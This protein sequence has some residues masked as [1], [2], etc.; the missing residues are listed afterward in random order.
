MRA[1][2]LLR[3][4]AL[5]ALVAL[6]AAAC[7]GSEE[8]GGSEGEE[9]DPVSDAA[10]TEG[11][12][13]AEGSEGADASE[14]G[15]ASEGTEGTEG[16][17][18][19]DAEGS[20]AAA[21]DGS[22]LV[23]GTLN[24]PASIDP[25]KCYDST[26]SNIL[27]NTTEQLVWFPPGEDTPEPRL[28]E[29]VE[30]SEDGLTYTFTLREGVTFHD[31]SELDADDVIYSLQ[32]SIDL[33]HPSGAAFLISAI[34]SMEAPDP[35]TVVITIAEAN[36][37]FLARLNY[38]IASIVPAESE[39][40]PTPPEPI[41]G[42]DPDA[43]TAEAD[44]FVNESSIIGTGPYQMTDYEEG[45]SMTLEAFPDYWD[46]APGYQTIRIQFF[47][48]SAQLANALANGEVDLVLNDLAPA[49]RTSVEGTDGIAVTEYSGG[50]I[51]YI[52]FNVNQPP[53]DNPD[54][55]RAVA[56]SID[57]QRIVDEVFEGAG[58]PL[59]SMI[60]SAFDVQ[61]DYVSDIEVPELGGTPIEF[62][63][64]YPLGRYGDTEPDVAET[65][66]RSLNESGLFNVTTE[67]AD[68]A[69][70]YSANLSTGA[71]GAF[72]LGWYPDY[73]D[74]D[75]YI[76][77]FYDSE[78][79]FLG[80]YANPEMDELITQEQQATDEAERAEIFD[81]IQQL[82]AE[83]MPLVPLYEEGTTVY[84]ADTVGNVEGTL[85]ATQTL[86]FY[87]LQPA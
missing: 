14:G 68:W 7:G 74:P 77:P 13:D 27:F 33:N 66:A 4:L 61:Q 20:E 62:D 23:Y 50:R 79:T 58:T 17:A 1:A 86:R 3:L 43:A 19:E 25:A 29:D 16:T 46:E 87:V 72:L 76:E 84:H 38:T 67:G 11:E 70:E 41:S 60:P 52:V 24:P 80:Y 32:R 18:G 55:R 8:P 39:D 81:Q 59:F 73:I 53:F 30:I 10:G 26:C 21:G 64:W 54:V 75:D 51:R 57:R 28:A 34:E 45:V 85:D 12:G 36:S 35:Q 65:I 83:D 40:Y 6:L 56:A 2:K 63:L 82:A 31:G 22:T 5:I 49:E 44:E 69:S 37:T 9:V 78:D 71:Y 47:Q 42:D 48:D 15:D